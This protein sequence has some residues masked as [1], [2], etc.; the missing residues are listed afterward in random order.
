MVIFLIVATVISAGSAIISS[1]AALW[2]ARAA[3]ESGESMS[4][5]VRA[6][7]NTIKTLEAVHSPVLAKPEDRRRAG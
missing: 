3:I 6:A 2:A 1:F 4:V 7:A 5:S